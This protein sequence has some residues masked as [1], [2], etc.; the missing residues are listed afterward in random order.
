MIA[1]LAQTD[2]ET[3]PSA[4]RSRSHIANKTGELP[5][6]RNDVA[7]VGYG[8]PDAYVVAVLDRYGN[9]ERRAAIDAIRD[10]IRTI[11]RRLTSA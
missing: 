6:V 9:N 10:V 7:I 4:L 11:D 1:L 5:G 8:D 2:R 3:I